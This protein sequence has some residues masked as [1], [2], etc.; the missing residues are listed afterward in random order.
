MRGG[1]REKKKIKSNINQNKNMWS[2]EEVFWRLLGSDPPAVPW[3]TEALSTVTLH[4]P[5]TTT[6][7]VLRP[8]THK[9]TVFYFSFERWS[10]QSFYLSWYTIELDFFFIIFHLLLHIFIF[11]RGR[12]QSFFSYHIKRPIFRCTNVLLV[13]IIIFWTDF[14]TIIWRTAYYYIWCLLGP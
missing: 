11:E 4:Y 14:F 2:A 5:L 1:L 9:R 7:S 10:E 8:W 3:L 13:Y 12:E 6:L